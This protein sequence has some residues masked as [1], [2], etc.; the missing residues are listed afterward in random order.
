M[1]NNNSAKT[2]QTSAPA[3]DAIRGFTAHVI[4]LRAGQAVSWEAPPR[5]PL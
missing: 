1:P 2:E 4:A 5:L 3:S